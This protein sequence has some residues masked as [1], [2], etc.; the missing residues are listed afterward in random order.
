MAISYYN[1]GLVDEA[2][3]ILD[4]GPDELINNIWKAYLKD[5]KKGLEDILTNSKIDFSF[6]F[7]RESIKI[8][9]W[10][11][12][13]HPNWKLDYLLS[14]NLWGKGRHKESQVLL[15]RIGEK[16]NNPIFYLIRGLMLE[17]LDVDPINDFKK[18]YTLNNKNWRISRALSNY[19]F[20]S[21]KY[22][23]SN[24]ILK[25]AFNNDKTNYIIGMDYVKTLVKLE[26]YSSAISVLDNLHIL[27]YEHAG[28][29]R[30]LYTNAYFGLAIKK[31]ISGNYKE[32][33]EIL[34][35]SKVW[36]ENLGVGKPYNPD[37]RI[38]DYLI[39]YCKENLGD[40]SSKKYLSDIIKYSKENINNNS[41][42]HILGYEA[43]K[44]IQGEQ[45]S[46]LFI[47]ELVS[48]HKLDSDEMKFIVDYKRKSLPKNYKNFDLLRKILH[49][50]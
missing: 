30:E 31:I 33:I 8:L 11:R 40:S 5:D 23:L 16:S 48:K 17:K 49:L 18:A 20:D 42:T 29:G 4:I 38:Q 36:P 50:K 25:K 1:R 24:N 7:R 34:D 39:F 10:A 13:L 41:A 6:P 2:I 21:K 44:I 19:Y 26:S 22:N 35:K 3:N 27:P 46:E 14:L 28:E 12:D 37:E 32:A 9:S 45:A 43:I 15:S 47:N